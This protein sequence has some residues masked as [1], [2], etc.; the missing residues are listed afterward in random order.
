MTRRSENYF[1]I[2]C[3]QSDYV[4]FRRSGVL[5]PPER[6]YLVCVIPILLNFEVFLEGSENVYAIC[7]LSKTN[8]GDSCTFDIILC[9]FITFFRVLYTTEYLLLQFLNFEVDLRVFVII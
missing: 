7:I 9:L 1:R 2:R 6:G 5:S 8:K 3:I 4:V